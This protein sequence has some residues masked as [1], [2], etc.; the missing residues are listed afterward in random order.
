MATIIMKRHWNSFI[1]TAAIVATTLSAV[2]IIRL[3]TK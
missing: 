2:S 1:V 3:E